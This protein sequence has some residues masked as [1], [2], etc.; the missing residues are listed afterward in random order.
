MIKNVAEIEE[1]KSKYK[2]EKKIFKPLYGNLKYTEDFN[3]FFELLRD[4]GKPLEVNKLIDVNIK[5]TL[6]LRIV[7]K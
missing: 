6:D 3:I 7:E 5:F 2:G 4:N 1:F